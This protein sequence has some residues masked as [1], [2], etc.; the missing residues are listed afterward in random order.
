MRASRQSLTLACMAPVLG[1]VLL[2]AATLVNL[3]LRPAD[4]T[5]PPT[6]APEAPVTGLPIEPALLK[7]ALE[8]PRQPHR[9]I[10]YL[11]ARPSLAD[12]TRLRDLTARRRAVVAALQSVA[13][14]SQRALR[15]Y[16]AEQQARGRVRSFT[17]FWVNNAIAVTAEVSVLFDLARRPEVAIIRAD[18]VYWLP[19]NPDS[20][21]SDPPAENF[22]VSWNVRRIRADL[23]WQ[24]LEIDG[25]GVVIASMDT[26]VDWQHPA[27]QTRY[28]G[29]N[30][31]GL[32]NH[33]G[34]WFCATNEGYLYP[35]DGH[36]HGTHTMAI[37]VGQDGI[38]VAPGAQWIAV[39]VFH[40]KGYAYESWVH[41]GFQWLLAPDGAPSLAPDIVNA[42]WGDNVVGNEAFRPDVQALRA[43]GILP[44]FSAGNH[45]P[46]PGT[47]GVPAGY[48]EAVAVGATDSDDEVTS[49][50]S[51]GPSPWVQVKPEVVAPGAEIRSA[52]PGG[53]YGVM[54]GTSMAAPH[55][56]GLAA[57]LLDA[58][59]N[60]TITDTIRVITSTAVPLGGAVPNTSAGWGR[61]DAYRAVASVAHAGFLE[62]HV[63]RAA[64]GG[65]VPAAIITVS[66]RDEPPFVQVTADEQGA[67]R[68][69]LPPGM[70]EVTAQA[71][72]YLPV[73]KT[74]IRVELRQTIELD[75]A[76]SLGP[77]GV[78]FGRVTDAETG[79]PLEATLRARDT[80]VRDTSDPTTGA[81]SLSL[82]PG[83]YVI[84]AASPAHRVITATVTVTEGQ[85]QMVNF[86]L[87]SAPTILLVDS[88]AWYYG[89]Q[90][91]YFQTALDDLGYLYDTWRVKDL[92][93]D[94][95]TADNL[96]SY[97]IT[98][99][100]A[101][102]DA[103]GFIGASGTI[104]GYL[105]S[106]GRLF[107]TGQDVG[108]WDG[109]GT[110][111]YIA[112]YFREHLQAVYMGD[113]SGVLQVEG[114]E[115]GP[116]AGL[117]LQL[118]GGD[119]ADNQVAPDLIAPLRPDHAGPVWR[120]RGAGVA[121]LQVGRCLPYRAL[122][123][124]FGFEG[125]SSRGQ[126]AEVMRRAI[127]SLMAPPEPLGFT[128]TA[129]RTQQVMAPGS[130]IT[131]NLTLRNT[132]QVTD[133][134][135]VQVE[136]SAWPASL[137][138]PSL[139]APITGLLTLGSCAARQLD[140]RL[141][142]PDGL[143]WNVTNDVTVYASS[144][145]AREKGTPIEQRLT[146]QSKT[147]APVLL[148]DDDRWHNVEEHYQQALGKLADTWTVGWST[149][150]GL[151][152]PTV[153]RLQMYPLVVWFTG[154]DWFETL[155]PEDE[156]RLGEYLSGGGRLF[157]SSQDYFYT[158]GM[159]DFSLRYLGVVDYA[160]DLTSTVVTGV[161]GNPVTHGLGPYLLSYTY[162][163]HSDGL[164]GWARTRLAFIGEEGQVAA[165][166]Y[167][168]PSG[169]FRTLFLAFPFEAL[170]EPD[171]AMVMKRALDWLSPLA[172]SSLAPGRAIVSAGDRVSYTLTL[173]NPGRWSLPGVVVTNILPVSLSLVE[174]SLTAGTYDPEDRT[175][176]WQGSL[177][178]QAVYTLSY[179]AELP[180]HLPAGALV[181]N[182]VTV[183][184]GT[185][186]T[187]ER[188]AVVRVNA[189]DL[190]PSAKWADRASVQPGQVI[191]YFIAMRNG[192]TWDAESVTVTDRLPAGL[193]LV[194][195][196]AYAT[197]GRV[198]E[199]DQGVRWTG[200][201][202]RRGMVVI[203]YQAWVSGWVRG[204]LVNVARLEDGFGSV[205]ER[206]A[207]VTVGHRVLFPVIRAASP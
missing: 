87:P 132:G 43:A 115:D 170:S 98:I 76:L 81:Y 97:D 51:R 151:G 154:Y 171:A 68:V 1:V 206:R 32:P 181:T 203:V 85:S 165:V 83:T 114:L 112:P 53:A 42:S 157:L 150:A 130:V 103:P 99:W 3:A 187:L 19:E 163:N 45:G 158:R 4:A 18:H 30:P 60:L 159:T 174:E 77:L 12:A 196:S 70:Y 8:A 57:L 119:S 48:P 190:S 11:A 129:L 201:V 168:P 49:F 186:I 38:G 34:N 92:R 36:G 61:I 120:Y 88:G 26:G 59:P 167:E 200:A 138:D 27:L 100:S 118:G 160:E 65:P 21:T 176:R 10:V 72:G 80:P 71:F 25:K 193:S 108:F 23:V 66:R 9:F 31:K 22:G 14:S 191:T 39:K 175:V 182:T 6:P 63:I 152:S 7:A 195:G 147:P 199:E 183:A 5:A 96:G 144:Q 146:L 109:G 37:A 44:V 156:E 15:P 86:A 2:L 89:S 127:E 198:Q 111:T 110:A 142:I 139:T 202:A 41:T 188:A 197:G 131:Y 67:Y 145:L 47:V 180:A 116:F 29:Y 155:T 74:A 24:A 107:L 184:D 207:S 54:S 124:A 56:A 179:Q 136:D 69:A 140:L 177:S 16:L 64:D 133:R 17:P 194:R 153:E 84:S 137:W 169:K 82:P 50:S 79:G 161:A 40:N 101:P 178:P 35:G 135:Q 125:I 117:S 78:M 95:P 55:V 134:Y 113:D 33:R 105:D 205:I 20:P 173:R 13:E 189:P 28:R 128:L 73:T 52:L 149:G 148:V 106:G 121:G 75:F 143:G 164:V 94:L 90:I 58:E 104:T 162:P 141:D 102:Q 91:S 122:Y 204:P 123:F 166:T 192:G 93:A 172:D 62:G 126:R 185:G 46:S